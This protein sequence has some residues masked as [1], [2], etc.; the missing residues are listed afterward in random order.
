LILRV[1]LVN[2][3][4][5]AIFTL[6]SSIVMLAIGMLIWI[7]MMPIVEAAEQTVLQKVVPFERQGRVFGFAQTVENAASPLTSFMIG[8]L[9]QLAVIPFM[10]DGAGADAIG[11]WFGRGRERGIALIFTIAGLVGIAATFAARA[12][13]WYGHLSELMDRSG[14]EPPS[15]SDSPATAVGSLE[16]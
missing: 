5:C 13:K 4:V 12:S 11:D 3:T 10:T 8:P 14:S 7:T 6:Q 2:W 16:R 15:T 1:N 9:A